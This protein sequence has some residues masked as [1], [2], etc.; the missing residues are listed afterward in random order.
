MPASSS[1]RI[2]WLAL[3][4]VLI[5]PLYGQT[6]CNRDCPPSSN[7]CQRSAGRSIETNQ[8]VYT[9]IDGTTCDAGGATGVCSGGQC[10]LA[11][12]AGISA[13]GE[14]DDPEGGQGGASGACIDLQCVLAAPD[15]P[16]VKPGVGRINCCSDAGCSVASGAYC[17]DPLDDGTSCDPTGIEPSGL[18]DQGGTCIDGT[19]IATAGNCADVACPTIW[20]EQCARDYCNPQTGECQEW[21]VDTYTECLSS[22]SNLPGF[23]QRGECRETNDECDGE[24][25]VSGPC[26]IRSCTFPCSLNGGVCTT[27]DY[28]TETPFCQVRNRPNGAR[29]Q[30]KPGTC[31]GGQCALG[32]CQ[33][34]GEC[35]DENP[36]TTNT[37]NPFGGLCDTD[38]V[39]DDTPCGVNDAGVVLAR[40]ESGRCLPDLCLTRDCSDGDSCTDDICNSPYGICTN[41]TKDDGEACDGEPGQCLFGNCQPVIP[42][43]QR[44]SDCDDFNSCT[45]DTC[46]AGLCDFDPLPNGAPCIG[47]NGQCILGSCLGFGF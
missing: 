36:C 23:C 4:P 26:V 21:W 29:C 15:D 39:L 34:D 14:C 16:C 3:V 40:C 35:D 13:F 45:E 1:L 32:A 41:P 10:V 8:C 19:C 30:G 46:P 6:S 22:D 25:C 17:N 37:C 9:N 18:G 33:D 44:D 47:E 2:L 31:F 43:C 11:G 7:P 5:F 24:T 27:E 12:C 42:R 28:L 38:P 20:E